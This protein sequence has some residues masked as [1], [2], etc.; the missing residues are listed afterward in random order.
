MHTL[1]TVNYYESHYMFGMEAF[2]LEGCSD[3]IFS[4]SIG[5]TASV[6]SSTKYSKLNFAYWGYMLLQCP[7]GFIYTHFANN[8]CYDVC[9]DGT[10]PDANNVSVLRLHLLQLLRLQNLHQLQ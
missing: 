8:L 7:Y 4:R 1:S 2:A 3:L 5:L 6:S 10:Y 9:P